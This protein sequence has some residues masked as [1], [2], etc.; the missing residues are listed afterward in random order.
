MK[1]ENQIALAKTKSNSVLKKVVAGGSALFI[2]GQAMALDHSTAIS[3][4]STDGTANVTA[5][6]TAVIA[7]MAVVTGIGFIVKLLGR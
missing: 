6:A 4:A 5:A 3:A 2:A 7:I 1:T